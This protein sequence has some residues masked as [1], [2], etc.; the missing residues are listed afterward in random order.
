MPE[1]V[2]NVGNLVLLIDTA[3]YLEPGAVLRYTG[4]SNYYIV[5]GHKSSQNRDLTWL[6]RTDYY[7]SNISL[8]GRGVIDGNGMASLVP[9]N[10]GVNLLAPVWVNG[11]SCDAI[12]F[13][14]SSNW[15]VIPI[16]SSD[17]TFT[18]IKIFNRFDMGEDD[19]IDV[20]E[21]TNGE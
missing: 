5:N 15:N 14:E 17:L 16:R 20:M 19:G 12:T 13:R 3:L 11:F 2:Y 18:N 7:S 4:D 9:S 1:G 21:S 10:L 6:L 8:H